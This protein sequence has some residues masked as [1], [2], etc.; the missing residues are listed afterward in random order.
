MINLKPIQAISAAIRSGK[1]ILSV[2]TREFFTVM[3]KQDSSPLTEADLAAH[4]IISESLSGTVPL[5]SE[6]GSSIPY[7]ERKAWSRYW[8]IDPLDG[9]KEFVK[10]N[11]EFTVNIALVSEG[12]PIFGVVYAPVPD[13]LYWGKAG[14][15]AWEVESAGR[16][17]SAEIIQ[18]GRPI[19]GPGPAENLVKVVASRSHL[20]AETEAYIE[21]V[22]HA[23]GTVKTESSGSS[24]KLCKVA[25]GEAHVYPRFAPTME[26]DTAAADA[27]C[28]AAGCYAVSVEDGKPL[29]YNKENL[30]NPWFLVGKDTGFIQLLS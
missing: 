20:S 4:R 24:L 7:D 11:G 23:Y 12:I 8:L 30:L 9:T 14:L 18:W 28:R 6:E 25:S 3:E 2:Y 27:V 5:L 1:E 16:L 10:R 26:W 17:S 15:G 29:R 19:K 13:I 22:K 21:K